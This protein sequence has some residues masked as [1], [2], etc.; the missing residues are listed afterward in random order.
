MI[1]LTVANAGLPKEYVSSPRLPDQ[2]SKLCREKSSYLRF[3]GPTWVPPSVLASSSTMYRRVIVVGASDA[4]F[5]SEA[6]LG[7]LTIGARHQSSNGIHCRIGPH[8]GVYCHPAPP[9][10]REVRR[11]ELS[12]L[13]GWMARAESPKCIVGSTPH[14]FRRACDVAV[15]WTS[16]RMVVANRLASGKSPSSK[17]RVDFKR[18]PTCSSRSWT[19][20]ST[21]C[22]SQRGRCRCWACLLLP[23]PATNEFCA[24]Y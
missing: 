14:W 21:T 22:S 20:S 13:P 4:G 18:N 1:C 23:A 12:M 24:F 5:G 15:W 19:K 6:R 17:S 9:F 2:P 11:S 7:T 8:E 10:I 16:V 3:L